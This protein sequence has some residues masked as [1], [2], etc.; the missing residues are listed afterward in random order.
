MPILVLHDELSFGTRHN[1][2]ELET[3]HS[4]AFECVLSSDNHSYSNNFFTLFF[5]V[6]TTVY[7]VVVHT[8]KL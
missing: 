3:L 5:V 6:V 7:T 4:Q 1:D 8:L 2:I